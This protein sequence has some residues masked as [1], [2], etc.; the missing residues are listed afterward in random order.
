MPNMAL[1][2]VKDTDGTTD[3]VFAS[4]NG[5]G[6]DGSPAVWRWEDTTKLPGERVRLEVSSRWNANRTARK[7]QYFFD[8][9]IVRPTAVTGVNEVIG[10][11]QN[12]SGDWIYPQ[13]ANDTQV[14]Q[15]AKL[16]T[17]LLNSSLVQSVFVTG[18]APN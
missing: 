10:H 8:Y 11:I 9:P 14:V 13:V 5:A 15:A 3:R 1:I 6:A 2:T 12:R 16:M 17:N 4:L 7:V 18:Y